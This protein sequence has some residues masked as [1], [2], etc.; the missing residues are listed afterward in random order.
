MSKLTAITKDLFDRVLATKRITALTGGLR[1][2]DSVVITAGGT[3]YTAAPTVGFSGGG[4]SGAAATASVLNGIVVAVTMTNLGSGYT[5]TPGVTFTP[6]SGGTGAAATA[7]MSPTTLDA[8]TTTDKTAGEF[9]ALVEIAPDVSPYSLVAGTDA[10]TAP[11]I[12]RPDDYAASTNEKV[13]KRRTWAPDA[14]QNRSAITGL[15]G[16]GATNLDGIVTLGVAAGL[17]VVVT[18]VGTYSVNYIYKLVAAGGLESSPYQIRP[19]DYDGTKI[20]RLQGLHAIQLQALALTLDQYNNN[21]LGNGDN[22]DIGHGG[23]AW[24]KLKAGPSAAF[25]ITGIGI[26]TGNAGTINIYNGTGQAM[27]LKHEAAGSSAANRIVTPTGADIVCTVA[28]LIYD[29]DG[30][31]WVVLSYA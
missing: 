14:V 15:T 22:N 5:S 9:L 17:T 4:G 8:V 29:T 3:G 25:A 20:W 26:A 21:S 11:D 28:S 30:T 24:M 31:R 6:V 12:I 18:I 23:Q 7:I 10:E 16:G 2:V 19:D 27:T 1:K 13:W